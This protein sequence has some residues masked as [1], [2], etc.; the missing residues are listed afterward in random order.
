MPPTSARA[1]NA[2]VL[3]ATDTAHPYRLD[4]SSPAYDRL[5]DA[6][7]QGLIIARS[8]PAG[9]NLRPASAVP[10]GDPGTIAR[11]LQRG[12]PQAQRPCRWGSFALVGG[13]RGKR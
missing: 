10:G 9:P 11:L 2:E 7:P 12:Y 5:R 13:R 3:A 4:P 1:A 6:T 8:L